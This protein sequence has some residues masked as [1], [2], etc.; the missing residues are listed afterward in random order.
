MPA[1][2]SKSTR[3]TLRH[4][5]GLTYTYPTGHAHRRHSLWIHANA[6]RLSP[7]RV[8]VPFVSGSHR[9]AANQ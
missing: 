8:S 7:L 2:T 4:I 3:E 6:A 5:G 9:A 1:M